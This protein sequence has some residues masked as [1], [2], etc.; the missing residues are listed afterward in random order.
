MSTLPGLEDFAQAQAALSAD[1]NIL[2]ETGVVIAASSSVTYGPM[3]VNNP[4]YAVAIDALVNASATFG[5]LLVSLVWSDPVT[6]LTVGAE[7]W[8]YSGTTASPAISN[9]LTF[10]RGPTKAGQLTITID[11]Y[12][13]AQ[14]ATVDV[15]V[16]QSSRVATRDD[17]RGNPNGG[18]YVTYTVPNTESLSCALGWV[19]AHALA[20]SGQISYQC[21]LYAGQAAFEFVS[22][23]TAAVGVEIFAPLPDRAS[24]NWPV[25]LENAAIGEVFTGA[26]VLP[27]CPVVVQITNNSAAPTN[28]TFSLTALEFA[29]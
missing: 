25:L 10:G 19:T 17:W 26:L 20:A 14:S 6:G 21:A 7:R 22:S 18:G 27:R 8:Y 4:A 3:A 5:L 11:N 9:G 1:L 23:A 15:A 24:G 16:W 2:Q 28:V 12:D 29:S 13:P